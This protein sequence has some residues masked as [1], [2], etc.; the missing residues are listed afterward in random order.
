MPAPGCKTEQLCQPHLSVCSAP[1]Q[2]SLSMGSVAREMGW[3]G[4]NLAICVAV[5]VEF[6]CFHV[7]SLLSLH[8][9]QR[10]HL[11]VEFCQVLLF[12]WPLLTR[13]GDK[14]RH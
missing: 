8:R 13:L 12:H 9:P 7:N 3:G 10:L 4:G 6:L 5:G 1:R 14:T 11:S 2:K